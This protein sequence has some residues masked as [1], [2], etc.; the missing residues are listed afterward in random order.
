MSSHVPKPSTAFSL[1]VLLS[2]PWPLWAPVIPTPTAAD[3]VLAYKAQLAARLAETEARLAAMPLVAYPPPMPP[4]SMAVAPKIRVVRALVTACSPE[5]PKDKAYY[6]KHGYEGSTYNIA[7]DLRVLPRGTKIRVPGYL[8]RSFPDKF[9]EVDSAG[10]SVIRRS[11][12]KG[13]VQIDV[14]FKTLYSARQWGSRMLD[15]EVIDP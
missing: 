9:W 13:I 8:D 5:D 12:R 3:R 1:L 2:I 11:T 15:V 6:A 14:K 7:A 10:G 4:Q